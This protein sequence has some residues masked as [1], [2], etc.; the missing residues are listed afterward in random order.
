MNAIRIRRHLD[1]ETLNL[2][3][4]R[5]LVGRNVE[6]IVLDESNGI[7]TDIPKSHTLE[8][9]RKA[10]HGTLLRYDDPFEPA[11]PPEDW[12]ALK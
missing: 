10:L 2:P 4:L 8:E 5:E 3:E 11:A 1:S 12:E 7:I 6:I 9:R